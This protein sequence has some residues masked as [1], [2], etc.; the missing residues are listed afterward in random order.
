MVAIFAKKEAQPATET[1]LAELYVSGEKT[2]YK[3]VDRWISQVTNLSVWHFIDDVE[4][5]NCVVHLKLF[6]G[7]RTGRFR[8][9]STFRTYVQR[10]TRY[11]CID[12]VRSQRVEREVDPGDLPMPSEEL[13]TG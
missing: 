8:G 12:Q 11:T 4:D 2:V 5:V 7:L 1:Q 3:Q 10:I 6:S 9:E 13:A